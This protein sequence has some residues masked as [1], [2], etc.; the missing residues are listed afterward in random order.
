MPPPTDMETK[1]GS[2]PR[3]VEPLL[4]QEACRRRRVPRPRR[5]GRP[6]A[7]SPAPSSSL[8]PHAAD[9]QLPGAQKPRP[10]PK[11][12][13]PPPPPPSPEGTKGQ[14]GPHSAFLPRCFRNRACGWGCTWAGQHPAEMTRRQRQVTPLHHHPPAA[15]TH[16]RSTAARRGSPCGPA[17]SPHPATTA[18]PAQPPSAWQERLPPPVCRAQP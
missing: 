2:P 7:C 16:L 14:R 17:R 5:G 10:R 9:C 4:G 1:A 11:P 18:V 12:P 3:L 13:R 6:R 15:C 8:S